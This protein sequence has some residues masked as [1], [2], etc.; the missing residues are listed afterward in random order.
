MGPDSPA[1]SLGLPITN[2]VGDLPVDA[3]NFAEGSQ[4]GFDFNNGDLYP[5]GIATITITAVDP[6]EV[7]EPGTIAVWSV[8]GLLGCVYGWRKKSAAN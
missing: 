3:L 2:V 8:L 7:P 1:G 6:A 4:P 5:N